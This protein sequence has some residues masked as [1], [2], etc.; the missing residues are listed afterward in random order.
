MRLAALL[1]VIALSFTIYW[2]PLLQDPSWNVDI[3]NLEAGITHRP[4]RGEKPEMSGAVW[5]RDGTNNT[6]FNFT[7][8]IVGA[9]Y[10]N[11]VKLKITGHPDIDVLEKI[12][13]GSNTT[14]WYN[15]SFSDL[16]NDTYAYSFEIEVSGDTYLHTGADQVFTIKFSPIVSF[17]VTPV[18]GMEGTEFTF[19]MKYLDPG[20]TP[21]TYVWA[22]ID[23][24]SNYGMINATYPENFSKG[25]NYSIS[26][27]GMK[28]GPGT[29]TYYPV[30]R[31]NG[32]M[33]SDR[34]RI[35]TFVVLQEIE[36]TPEEKWYEDK[37]C[38][39]P[40][41]FMVMLLLFSIINNLIM[42]S[43]MKKRR[44]AGT[45]PLGGTQG[46]AGSRCSNCNSLVA[47]DDTFCPHCGEYFEDEV[48][49]P[50]CGNIVPGE[51]ATCEKCGITIRGKAITEDFQNR[52][53][54]KDDIRKTR[55]ETDRVPRVVKGTLMADSVKEDV[56]GFMCSMCGAAVKGSAGKCNECGTELE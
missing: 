46:L 44:M 54:W 42:R 25:V 7:L 26:F 13:P 37:C 43:K 11:T 21:P 28:F 31:L 22:V 40:L 23:N 19:N 33:Y 15:S 3:Q 16:A 49:C 29:Y 48:F 9:P 36:D 34:Y 1:L 45:A 4:T 2:G 20:G 41:I 35:K 24:T 53:K 17:S 47:D 10:V 27:Q 6:K 50:E 38:F 18:S 56:D 12:T 55:R 39:F 32:R 5:P 30:V 8:T 14:F 51:D 52:E